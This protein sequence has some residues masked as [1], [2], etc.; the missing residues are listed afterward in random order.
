MTNY[1]QNKTCIIVTKHQK[2]RVIAPI[3]ED[4]LGLKFIHGHRFDTDSLGTFSGEIERM[5]D[6]L[7]TV[8]DKCLLGAHVP[9]AD[10]VIANEGSFGPHPLIP[11]VKADEEYLCIYDKNENDFVVEKM[12]FFETNFLKEKISDLIQLDAVLGKLKY[13][14]HGIMI[15]SEKEIIKDVQDPDL[16]RSHVQAMLYEYGQCTIETDMRAM[17]NPTRMQCIGQLTK[18]LASA[19]LNKCDSCGWHGFQILRQENGLKCSLCNR[20]TRSILYHLYQCK[21]CGFEKKI[22]YPNKK[23]MEDPAYCDWCNP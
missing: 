21:K 13:P 12:I 19:L 2:E 11:F 1:F 23:Q 20:P 8:K 5:K 16:I 3:L 10:F 17:Y 4:M 6:P 7:S 15:R 22:I 9:N 14:S 18:K